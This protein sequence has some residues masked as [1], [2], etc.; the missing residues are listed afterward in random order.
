MS[1]ERI[2]THRIAPYRRPRRARVKLDDEPVDDR[3]VR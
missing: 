1:A 3:W 2:F